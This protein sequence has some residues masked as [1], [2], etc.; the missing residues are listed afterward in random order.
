MQAEAEAKR[1]PAKADSDSESEPG[2][3]A[4]EKPVESEEDLSCGHSGRIDVPVRTPTSN[5]FPSLNRFFRFVASLGEV[6]FG[7]RRWG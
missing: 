2:D 3:D 7:T 1:K 4:P 5:R 6:R